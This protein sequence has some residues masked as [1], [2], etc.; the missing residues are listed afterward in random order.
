MTYSIKFDPELD[1]IMVRVAGELDFPTLQSI[2]K[3]V[4]ILAEKHGCRRVF[5][6]LCDAQESTTLE[7]YN[8]PKAAEQAGVSFKFKRALLTNS[9]DEFGFLETVFVNM[10]HQV[11]LFTSE[12]EAKR[13]LGLAPD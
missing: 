11:R 6:D 13:W 3:D 10:G 7:I 12:A 4:N 5:N 8:M 2:A 9:L 1:C